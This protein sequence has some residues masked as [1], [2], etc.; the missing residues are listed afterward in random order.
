MIIKKVN[1]SK[2]KDL[3]FNNPYTFPNYTHTTQDNSMILALIAGVRNA[4]KTT[5]A[6]NIIEL[7][8]K[9]L[10]EGDAMVYF[11]SPTKDAKVEYF[12][13]KFPDNFEY[14]DE[15]SRE[16]M[17][18]ILN[19]IKERVENWKSKYDLL[20]LLKQY[21][22]NPKKLT[23]EEMELLEEMDYLQDDD[24]MENFRYEHPC[25]STLI[26]DDS[27]GNDMICEA[28]SIQG[29]WFQKFALKHRHF[30][31]YCNIFILTQHI[32]S[33][34]KYFRTNANWTILFPFRDHNVLKSVF[35]EYSVLFDNNIDNFLKFMEDIR[36]KNDHSF[37]SIYYDKIQYIRRG[38]NEE[39]D[40]KIPK[41]P[42]I[43]SAKIEFIDEKK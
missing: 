7:E 28:R 34:C 26:I 42:D 23:F 3:N 21:L 5:V 15:L 33:C 10:L 16:N 32:K 24:E 17:E 6:L 25:L 19:K 20:K 39:I 22:T 36:L 14:Y 9:H 27:I 41:P 11:I 12:I 4:G 30:P 40:F 31:Y 38:F 37:C 18:T 2:V 29:R 8:K 1:N 35:D 13:E 43:C